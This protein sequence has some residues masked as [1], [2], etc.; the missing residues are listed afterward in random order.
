MRKIIV[1]ITGVAPLLMH[2]PAS[3]GR[4]QGGGRPSIPSAVDEA[5][6]SRYLM[7]NGKSLALKAD[8]IHRCLEK[9]ST[10]LRVRPREFL[11]PYVTGSVTV[12]PEWIT[13]N[14]MK[15]EVDVRRAVVK[16]NGIMRARAMVWPWKAG[17][18]LHY[19]D[20]V[21]SPKFMDDVFRNEVMLRAGKAIALLDYRPK[22]GRFEVTRWEA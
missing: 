1:E 12:Q 10:G 16:K 20:T 14:T 5:A 7:P 4:G 18:E 22:Y 17:F 11:L 2:N 13:L 19:D 6:A 9:A 3:M 15:Y 21:L 8:H